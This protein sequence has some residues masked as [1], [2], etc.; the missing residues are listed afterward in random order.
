MVCDAA[1]C[2]MNG[3]VHDEGMVNHVRNDDGELMAV[4]MVPT[5]WHKGSKGDWK[6]TVGTPVDFSKYSEL[7]SDQLR[8]L[9]YAFPSGKACIWATSKYT[10]WPQPGDSVWFHQDNYVI[11]LAEV[12][13]AFENPELAQA[14]WRD[15]ESWQKGLPADPSG[16]RYIFVFEDPEITVIPKSVIGPLVGHKATDRWQGTR[17]LDEA[18]SNKLLS[19]LVRTILPEQP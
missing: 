9:N 8:W 3:S 7:T 12:H 1:A 16:W 11:A 13:A 2:F 6:A 5:G 4:V 10:D 18:Q 19:R 17:R 14:L 15:I